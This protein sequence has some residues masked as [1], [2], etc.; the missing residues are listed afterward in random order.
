MMILILIV[1]IMLTI[2]LIL[3]KSCDKITESF[4]GSGHLT[5]MDNYFTSVSL[6]KTLLQDS[7]TLVDTMRKIINQVFHRILCHR[8]YAKLNH[9]RLI[10]MEI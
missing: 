10:S 3:M 5:T 4:K 1:M 7:L 6:D 2:L 9:Q 8:I